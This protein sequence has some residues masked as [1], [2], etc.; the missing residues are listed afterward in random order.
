MTNACSHVTSQSKYRAVA[1]DFFKI[2]AILDI[3]PYQDRKSC[4][5][6]FG[7]C[8]FHCMDVPQH[9]YQPLLMDTIPDFHF[10]KQYYDTYTICAQGYLP[11]CVL[12]QNYIPKRRITG[13]KELVHFF[14]GGGLVAFSWAA[15]AAYGGSQARCLIRAVAVSLHQSHSNLWPKLHLPPTPQLTATPDP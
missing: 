14:L 13:S 4:L 8:R 3:F 11:P 15:P 2:N 10:H 6:H 9:I 12:P 1:I 7:L 5:F